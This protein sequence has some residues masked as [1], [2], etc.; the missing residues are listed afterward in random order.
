MRESQRTDQPLPHED[1]TRN[2]RWTSESTWRQNSRD[3]MWPQPANKRQVKEVLGPI[4][5]YIATYTYHTLT[6]SQYNY[7]SLCCQSLRLHALFQVLF[8]K[9]KRLFLIFCLK[10][11]RQDVQRTT[12]PSAGRNQK[13]QTLAECHYFIR[14]MVHYHSATKF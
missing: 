12:A 10:S 8:N 13:M 7:I 11:W 5:I 9:K 2:M 14:F 1:S 6:V 4:T 3:P